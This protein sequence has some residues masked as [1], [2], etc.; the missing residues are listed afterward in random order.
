MAT[1]LKPWR[2]EGHAQSQS[3]GQARRPRAA[4]GGAGAGL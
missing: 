3:W 4:R 2:R 1:V